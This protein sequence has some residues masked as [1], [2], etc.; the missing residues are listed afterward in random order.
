MKK[1]SAKSRSVAP[2]PRRAKE[3]AEAPARRSTPPPAERASNRPPPPTTTRRRFRGAAP[4]AARHAAKHAAEAAAR[5]QEPPRPGSAR[6]TLR[7]PEE[8]EAL[9]ARVGQLHEALNR[10]RALKKQLPERFFEAGSMLKHIRDERLFD[11][12]GY[13]T[14]EAFVEREV[15]LGSKTLCLRLSR[16]PE[17]FS[18]AA[19]REYGLDPL[20]GALET[21]EQAAMRAP[22]PALRPAPR[23]R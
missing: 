10:V 21:L 14:F 23:G 19:A 1:S 18:E 8:A 6:A 4:W 2:S 17:V 22:R 5:N 16:I 11:A 7:T 9:K 3:P 20:L 12:K 15:D 13:A